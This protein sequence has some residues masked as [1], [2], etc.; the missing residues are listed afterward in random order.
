MAYPQT[1]REALQHVQA[2]IV[3]G[4]R[5]GVCDKDGNS[6]S[7]N[8]VMKAKP[9]TYRPTAKWVKGVGWVNLV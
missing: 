5:R 8:G 7:E 4:H 2:A 6:V 9:S 1:H 3:D